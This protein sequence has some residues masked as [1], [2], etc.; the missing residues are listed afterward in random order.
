LLVRLF[1]DGVEHFQQGF[2]FVTEDV[3]SAFCTDSREVEVSTSVKLTNAVNQRLVED[4]TV[5]IKGVQWAFSHSHHQP[6]KEYGWRFGQRT[7]LNHSFLARRR[8]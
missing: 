4:L 2:V 5:P 3:A 8:L 6:F 7:S 1:D